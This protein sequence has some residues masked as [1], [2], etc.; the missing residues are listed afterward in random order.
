MTW[1]RATRLLTDAEPTV[2]PAVS[3]VVTVDGSVVYAHRPDRVFD[4]ASLTKVVWTTEA[5]LRLVDA[6]RLALDEPHPALQPGQ[7]VARLLQHSA[8]CLWWKDF[9]GLPDRAAILR[10]ARDEPLVHEPGVE[11]VYSDLGFLTLGALLEETAA[12]RIDTLGDGPLR[13]GDATAEPTE[14][15][16]RGVVHDENARAMGGIAP[17]AGLFGR[18]EE[19][20]AVAGRWLRG[21]VPLAAV[22]FARKGAGSHV[23]GWDT[24]SGNMSSAG[25]KPPKDAVGHTGFTGTSVWMSPSRRTVAVLLT[26]RV[27][28]GRDPAAIRLLRFKWHQAVWDAVA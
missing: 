12:A 21:D 13:W 14:H 24:P 16:L 5:A 4:L 2:A 15:G 9:T 19:V 22:A 25:G 6:G 23:L 7:T 10:A 20:A 8:G 26:N 1:D 27:A 3:A 18:A 17:H 28:Y 11:H